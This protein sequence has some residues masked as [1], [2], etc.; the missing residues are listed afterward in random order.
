MNDVLDEPLDDVSDDSTD[1]GESEDISS[2]AEDVS[3]DAADDIAEDGSESDEGLQD[4]A[5]DELD[6]EIEED[7]SAED[8][9]DLEEEEW[10]R[11]EDAQEDIPEDSVDDSDD[12]VDDSTSDGSE[13][14][15]GLQDDTGVEL[16]DVDDENTADSK[17]PHTAIDDLE[18]GEIADGRVKELQDFLQEEARE[19]TVDSEETPW[20]PDDAGSDADAAG[21]D[22]ISDAEYPDG[23]AQEDELSEGISKDV[24]PDDAETNDIGPEEPEEV[25]ASDAP[26]DLTPDSDD[27]SEA[28]DE[29]PEPGLA[30]EEQNEISDEA[31]DAADGLADVSQEDGPE[32]P[33][34]PESL[35]D[36]EEPADDISQY[37]IELDHPSG[38]AREESDA[39]DM[40]GQDMADEA[41]LESDADEI[42]EMPIRDDIDNLGRWHDIPSDISEMENLKAVNPNYELDE[43]WQNNCQRCVPTFEMRE[44]G[45][46]VTA[47]PWGGEEDDLQYYPY[48]VWESPDVISTSG[49]GLQDIRDTMM[50]WED[51]SRAQ[52]VLQWKPELTG[53]SGGGHT[54]IAERQGD[55]VR[56]LD[57]Q[58]GE[59][60]AS[61][62]FESAKPGSVSFCRTDNLM[63]S[64]R[65]LDCCKG[66]SR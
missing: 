13:R 37:E 16:D 15:E 28:A 55:A 65:I 42:T 44:R 63:P 32:T 21:L 29:M 64:K 58:T 45:Y 52:V 33:A 60:D 36:V 11:E 7:I 14:E 49:D 38:D 26:G 62:Y 46:D 47:L 53:G 50:S 18:D 51:G 27:G 66:V 12:A 30:Q 4:D 34:S 3:S 1:L 54:F 39:A 40:P 56:F 41:S 35:D 59:S 24:S 31:D 48:D 17:S 9:S 43:A 61:Y 6:D 5:G 25:D 22:D 10:S 8:G 19:D 57:P 2:E 20:I 23:Q